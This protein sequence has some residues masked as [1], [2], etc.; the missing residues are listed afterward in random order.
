M[1][2]V[3][4]ACRDCWG[5][6]RVWQF[7]P[8]GDA[9]AL[10]GDEERDPSRGLGAG[11]GVRCFG[12]GFAEMARQLGAEVQVVGLGYDVVAD[13][14]ADVAAERTAALAWRPRLVMVVHSE[15][16]RGTLQPLAEIG[17]I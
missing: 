14:V 17:A 16:P 5:R 2:A 7:C 3:R 4:R 8:V 10:G 15:T 1:D 9:G 11:G 12:Y 6:R 13:V